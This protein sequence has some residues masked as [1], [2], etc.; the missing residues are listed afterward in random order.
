M[1]SPVI[2]ERCLRPN[3]SVSSLR[4]AI[5]G[6]GATRKTSS[7]SEPVSLFAFAG[8]SFFSISVKRSTALVSTV[9][10]ILLAKQFPYSVD[11]GFGAWRASRYVDVDRYHAVH[12]LS[13]I[14]AALENPS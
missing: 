7:L 6:S 5:S 12:A 1:S 10:L 13:G 3:S 14:V 9:C 2:V 8:E 11:D 4:D